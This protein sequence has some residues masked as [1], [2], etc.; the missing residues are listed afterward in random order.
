MSGLPLSRQT[1]EI[2][3][4][5]AA[6]MLTGQ[7]EACS[8]AVHA[9]LRLWGGAN[10]TDSDDADYYLRSAMQLAETSA[11]LA[12]AI[13]KVKGELHQHIR[14]ERSGGKEGASRSVVA[15]VPKRIEPSTPE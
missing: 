12:E 3:V 6:L 9:C 15:N 8:K 2:L 5:D 14:V 13:A 10:N 7:V 11:R 1:Y 4:G